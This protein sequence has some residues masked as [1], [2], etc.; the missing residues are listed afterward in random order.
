MRRCQP[1]PPDRPAHHFLLLTNLHPTPATFPPV[2]FG[3]LPFV[4]A[5][6]R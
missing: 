3:S 5:P 4:H 2:S 1:E 6:A